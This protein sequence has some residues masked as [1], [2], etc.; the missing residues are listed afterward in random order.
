MNVAYN[1]GLA[2]VQ[3]Q[4][5]NSVNCVSTLVGCQPMGTVDR[6]DRQQDKSVEAD[7]PVIILEHNKSM[8]GLDLCDMLIAL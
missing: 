2:V 5:N 1:S 6:Q 7:C 8:R 3:W 4:D